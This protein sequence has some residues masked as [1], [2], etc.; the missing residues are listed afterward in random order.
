MYSSLSCISIKACFVLH[1]LVGKMMFF[2]GIL[3]LLW[4]ISLCQAICSNTTI[5][6]VGGNGKGAECQQDHVIHRFSDLTANQTNCKTVRIYSS[7][8]AELTFSTKLYTWMIQWKRQ[9]FT[10]H[11]MVNS[12][13]LSAGMLLVSGSVR[14]GQLITCFFRMW[15]S[16]TVRIQHSKLHSSS[17]MLNTH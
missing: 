1:A 15:W 14:T 17:E 7:W 12:A 6:V 2:E 5:C 13:S 9:R 16:S 11:H 4:G 10:V 3:L 8:Q